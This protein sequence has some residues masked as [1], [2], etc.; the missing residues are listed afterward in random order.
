MTN[1]M[2]YGR[3]GD[4]KQDFIDVAVNLVQQVNQDDTAVCASNAHQAM[5]AA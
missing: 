4:K 5:A 2:K 1:A 3:G